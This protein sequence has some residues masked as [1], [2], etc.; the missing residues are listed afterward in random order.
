MH[1]EFE[2]AKQRVFEFDWDSVDFPG[3]RA[4]RGAVKRKSK[5]RGT[6]WP[7]MSGSE[8]WHLVCCAKLKQG[9]R[10]AE[11]MWSYSGEGPRCLRPADSHA[12]RSYHYKLTYLST[13]LLQHFRKP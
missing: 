4:V 1:P 6:L 11:R 7:D 10:V 5:P 12:S 9:P 8:G 3:V 13:V 2:H